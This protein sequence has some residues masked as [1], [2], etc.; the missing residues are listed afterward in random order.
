MEG[1]GAGVERMCKIVSYAPGM[2]VKIGFSSAFH[3]EFVV[4]EK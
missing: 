3:G 4:L 1:V 2:L